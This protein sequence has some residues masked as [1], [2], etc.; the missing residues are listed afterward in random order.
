MFA[1]KFEEII[2]FY[3]NVLT[4]NY[5]TSSSLSYLQATENTLNIV[6][7]LIAKYLTSK[8]FIQL[9]IDYILESIYS[10]I[11]DHFNH[12]ISKFIIIGGDTLVNGIASYNNLLKR[13]EDL[14]D[15]QL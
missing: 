15:F 8:N 5:K 11:L 13:I 6:E 7:P 14:H 4:V 2:K 10:T 12:D 9:R 3:L 1:T